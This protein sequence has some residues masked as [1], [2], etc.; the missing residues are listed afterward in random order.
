MPLLAMSRTAVD[1]DIEGHLSTHLRH[2][3]IEYL[4]TDT[5]LFEDDCF[6]DDYNK[7]AR[8]LISFFSDKF[9]LKLE[10]SPSIAT[11][12]VELNPNFEQWLNNLNNW[13]LI[14]L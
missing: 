7:H 14:G 2:T 9:K 6:E 8:P 12:V 11:P 4:K 3:V 1:A 5:I 10:P 13:Q